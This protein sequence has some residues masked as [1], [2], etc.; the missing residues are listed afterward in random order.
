MG[1]P[2]ETQP[3][4]DE[5][6]STTAKPVNKEPTGIMASGVKYLADFPDI[7]AGDVRQSQAVKNPSNVV[8]GIGYGLG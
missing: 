6:N 1:T 7:A 8:T 5:S 2:A 3:K 4:L